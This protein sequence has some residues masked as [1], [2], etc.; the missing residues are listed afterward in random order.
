MFIQLRQGVKFY[1]PYDLFFLL[2]QALFERI[3]RNDSMKY[4]DKFYLY[5]INNNSLPRL[6]LSSS[7]DWQLKPAFFNQT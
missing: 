5:Q 4:K 1:L 2:G 3:H 7:T 6:N